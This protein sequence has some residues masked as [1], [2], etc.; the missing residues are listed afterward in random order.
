MMMMIYHDDD[1][2]N[3]YDDAELNLITPKDFKKV[4]RSSNFKKVYAI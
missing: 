1:K 3:H 4:I 2:L